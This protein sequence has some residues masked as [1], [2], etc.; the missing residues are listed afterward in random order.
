MSRKLRM[1]FFSPFRPQKSGIADYSEELLPALGPLADVD[2]ITGPYTLSN[3]ALAEQFRIRGVPEFTRDAATYDIAIYQVG[4]NFHHHGYMIPSMQAAPGILVLHDYCL[5]FLTLGLTVRDGNFG[6]LVETLRPVY[7]KQSLGLALRLLLNMAEPDR[8]TFAAPLINRSKGVIVHSEFARDLVRECS[9]DKPIRVI[10]MG[11]PD[12][13]PLTPASELR[14]RYR[15]D[16]SS[17]V[18]ASI[19]TVSHTKRLGLVLEALRGLKAACPALRYLIVGGGNLGDN[20]RRMIDEFGLRDTVVITGWVSDMD[21][22]GLIALADAIVDLRYP[23]GA[24]TSASLTRAI[25][26]GKPLIVSRQGAFIELPDEFAVKIPVGNEL[27]G[28]RAA[29]RRLIDDPGLRIRMSVSSREYFLRNLRIGHSA[30]AYVEFSRFASELPAPPVAEW[31][32]R[33]SPP[34]RGIIAAIYKL[35]RLG[36]LY[37]NYG[38]KDTIR[39]IHEEVAAN[40]RVET[41]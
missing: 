38:W 6:A 12:G 31:P 23:S 26:I 37:R 36:Y 7:G 20:A 9:P 32:R 15:L 25:G 1:A 24:E 11:V 35:T 5:Q 21:Y 13:T 16:A 17:F 14:E 30:E 19:S 3:L 8:L 2:L 39:R 33:A 34:L 10:P 4:N 40:A 22:R 29:A 18:L 28:L 27:Q 41:A